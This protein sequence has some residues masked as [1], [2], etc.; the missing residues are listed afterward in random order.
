MADL[1][2]GSM[3]KKYIK[4]HKKKTNGKRL[5]LISSGKLNIVNNLKKEFHYA[6]LREGMVTAPPADMPVEN[7]VAVKNMA[8]INELK[9]I[10]F[11][12]NEDMKKYEKLYKKYLEE[13][14]TRQNEIN[15]DVKGKVIN[16]N[17]GNTISK[18]YV[19]SQ[20]VAR[21]FQPDAW[22]G[23]DKNTCSDPAKTVGGDVFSKLSTGPNMGIG[24]ACMDG[25]LNVSDAGGSVAWLDNLGYK[26]LYRDFRNKDK[27]CPDAI[28]DLT[29]EQFNAIPS[30][31]MQ[32]NSDKCE[33]TSLKGGTYVTLI[34]LNRKLM[35]SI[36]QMKN[37]VDKLEVEDKKLDNEVENQKKL[38]MDKYSALEKEKEK[39]KKLRASNQTL[40]AETNEVL[41]DTGAANF[42]YFIWA[43]VGGTFGYAIYKYSSQ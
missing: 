2:Q 1:N 34:N 5:R 35:N 43:V 32:E 3:F 33:V 17:D 27:T 40:S 26:H 6:S 15:T 36:R 39:I 37:L 19:N 41:L 38:L 11:Q 22:G 18:Y 42:K 14:V 23:R 12:F 29:S 9:A 31:A 24:E 21:K 30:G 4:E 8:E 20:G 10:E 13:L 16:Y 28:R 7:P 25:G